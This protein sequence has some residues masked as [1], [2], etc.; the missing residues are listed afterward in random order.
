MI[1]NCNCENQKYFGKINIEFENKIYGSFSFSFNSISNDNISNCSLPNNKAYNKAYNK[2]LTNFLHKHKNYTNIT[3]ITTSIN[4]VTK[5][6]NCE[7]DTNA[8][9]GYYKTL[10][11]SEMT[12]LYRSHCVLNG[13][14]PLLPKKLKI[15]T[16]DKLPAPSFGYTRKQNEIYIL[17]GSVAFLGAFINGIVNETA[18]CQD[19]IIID[20]IP[21]VSKFNYDLSS[22]IVT[23]IDY[24]KTVN[25]IGGLLIHENGFIYAVARSVV[26][27]L[28]PDTLQIINYINLPLVD[29]DGEIV[30]KV[31]F[32]SYLTI[33]N[34]I[35]VLKNG[36]LILK[37]FTRTEPGPIYGV[38]V[39]VDPDTLELL[40]IFLMTDGTS[41][42]LTI[43]TDASKNQ[44]VST[45]NSTEIIRYLITDTTF[46]LDNNYTKQYRTPDSTTSTIGSSTLIFDKINRLS[47]SNNN[48]CGPLT[49]IQIY[50]YPVDTSSS[51][52]SKNAFSPSLPGV[53]FF[54]IASD[55]IINQYVICYDPINKSISCNKLYSNGKFEFIWQQNNLTISA[56]IAIVVNK[57]H[58]YIDDYVN[59]YDYF[60]ILSLSTGIELA[61]IK[62]QATLPTIGGIFPG[63]NNDVY[64]VSN[65]IGD[66]QGYITRIFV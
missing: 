29:S 21:Y 48:N 28:D 54:M 2:A 46:I 44:Y 65:Q 56:C 19:N 34:G 11:P 58:I 25:Y 41:A 17:G 20:Y 12:D 43:Y 23:N 59:G 57:N 62:T 18:V 49:G 16:F 26:Y 52:I 64:L 22:H 51:I 66:K 60:V 6:K 33:Y 10:W 5:I 32:N 14:L 63:M 45:I 36:R 8:R 42:R 50:N 35:Q 15:T 53:N 7:Y 38:M 4:T 30:Y 13:G 39:Q 24:G 40:V 27:K 31:D 61:R 47:F 1:N 55:N 37:G 3:K 9:I